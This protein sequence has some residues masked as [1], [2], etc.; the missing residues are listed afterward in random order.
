MTIKQRVMA[1]AA[2][3]TAIKPKWYKKIDVKELDLQDG[4]TCVLGEMYGWYE[5]G[6]AELGISEEQ[7][8]VL[9]FTEHSEDDYDDDE[10]ETEN[11]FGLTK[12]WKEVIRKLQ[13][14]G[15]V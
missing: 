5:D 14:Y 2:F 9:G 6:L 13:R 1:G 10:I 8:K 12:T 15:K 3:L 4:G 11:W 7:A